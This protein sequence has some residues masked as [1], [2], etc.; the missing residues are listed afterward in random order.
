M[1]GAI[2]IRKDDWS[3]VVVLTCNWQWCGAMNVCLRSGELNL[4]DPYDAMVAYELIELA[5]NEE[6]ENMENEKLDG[7]TFDLAEP[8]G[9]KDGRV[10]DHYRLP[11]EYALG[12]DGQAVKHVLRCA[13]QQPPMLCNSLD[14]VWR[15]MC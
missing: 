3:A 13:V 1:G 4:D 9:F 15:G 5:W 14:G 12:E 11:D 10:V 2:N 6:G 8:P 7:V